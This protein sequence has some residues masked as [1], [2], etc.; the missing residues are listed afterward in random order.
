MK[1]HIK[2][3]PN[4]NQTSTKLPLITVEVWLKFQPNF[5]Q[6]STIHNGSLV[7]TLSILQPNLNQNTNVSCC[8]QFFKNWFSCEISRG[9]NIIQ[10][11]IK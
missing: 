9:R 2:L 6:T 10:T 7:E 3:Q 8:E 11:L 5:Y 4:F 1:K